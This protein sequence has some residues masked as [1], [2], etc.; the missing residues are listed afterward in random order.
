MVAIIEFNQKYIDSTYE[1]LKDEEIQQL[2]M[3]TKKIDYKSNRIFW[4]EYLNN[5]LENQKVYAILLNNKHIGNCGFK[6]INSLE[7]ELWIYLGKSYWGC[8]YGKI[9]LQ[10][11]IAVGTDVLKLKHIYLNVSTE[12]KRALNLYVN[13]GFK[14]CKTEENQKV[15]KLSIKR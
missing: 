11:L 4:L 14:K 13:M 8:G 6:N 10:K 3:L 9:A 12:N 15:I 1:I 2:F 7:A 5:K